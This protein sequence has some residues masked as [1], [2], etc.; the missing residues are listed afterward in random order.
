MSL[1]VDT[2]TEQLSEDRTLRKSGNSVV[3]SLPPELLE[4]VGMEQGDEVKVWARFGEQG[5]IVLEATR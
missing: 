5:R 1:S 2:E 3:C 4:A